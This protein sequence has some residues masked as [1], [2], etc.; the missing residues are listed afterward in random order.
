MLFNC[1]INLFGI[2]WFGMR[3]DFC[4]FLLS[5]FPL[6]QEYANIAYHSEPNQQ[7]TN[8]ANANTVENQ[9]NAIGADR[10]RSSRHT[11][12]KDKH[13]KKSVKNQKKNE[14]LKPV[15]PIISIDIPD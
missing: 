14:L 8:G 10:V 11:R 9:Q 7:G 13:C 15:V 4:Q 12:S 3:K 5:V 6:L 2:G 1:I